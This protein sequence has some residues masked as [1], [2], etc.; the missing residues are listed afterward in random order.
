MPKMNLE[1]PD[2]LHDALN[3]LADRAA[4]PREDLVLEAVEV[5]LGV[6]QWQRAELTLALE[7]AD[8]GGFAPEAEVRELLARF[9]E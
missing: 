1:L 8:A 2:D 6:K 7:E 3:A 9:R 4:R 5:Y